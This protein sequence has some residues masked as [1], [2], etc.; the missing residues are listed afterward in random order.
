MKEKLK[1]IRNAVISGD[2]KEENIYRELRN[3][4]EDI[5]EEY[6]HPEKIST[7]K[8]DMTD[9]IKRY[10]YSVDEY[11]KKFG[12]VMRSEQDVVKHLASILQGQGKGNGEDTSDDAELEL[13][14][15]SEAE[16]EL[17]N[18]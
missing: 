9:I 18:L 5:T 8:I 10:G 16:I 14:L 13:E 7:E 17:L 11:K 15:E 6:T 1:I 4:I 12:S 2:S 3:I